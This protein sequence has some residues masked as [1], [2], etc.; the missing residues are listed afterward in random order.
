MIANLTHPVAHRAP[1]ASA[2]ALP[3]AEAI[4]LRTGY[5]LWHHYDRHILQRAEAILRETAGI[6]PLLGAPVANESGHPSQQLR[7]ATL[8]IRPHALPASSQSVTCDQPRPRNGQA[9]GGQARGIDLHNEMP[10]WF[11][12]WLIAVFRLDALHARA[13]Q[14]AWYQEAVTGLYAALQ[15]TDLSA[16]RYYE[17]RCPMTL[18]ELASRRQAQ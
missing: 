1:T 15:D 12:E 10:Q 5:N 6:T 18:N 11:L 8:L 14:S 13:G 17:S 4:L 16:H 3:R 2:P 7:L 9:R